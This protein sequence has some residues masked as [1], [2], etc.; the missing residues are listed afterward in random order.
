[1][2][3]PCRA[4]G[5]GV[6]PSRLGWRSV[7]SQAGRRGGSP[8]GGGARPAPA[9]WRPRGRVSVRRSLGLSAILAVAAAQA[10]NYRVTYPLRVLQ[11]APPPARL[12]AT[13]GVSRAPHTGL[14]P[15]L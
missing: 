3:E 14:P 7:W 9:R 2:R 8:I 4:R 6:A 10:P 11:G 13:A 5:C 1:M 12:L 15:S